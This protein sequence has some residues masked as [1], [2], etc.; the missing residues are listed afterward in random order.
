MHVSVTFY[1]S[2]SGFVVSAKLEGKS[3]H[4]TKHMKKKHYMEVIDANIKN[5]SPA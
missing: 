5:C 4:F 3:V 1:H 2:D